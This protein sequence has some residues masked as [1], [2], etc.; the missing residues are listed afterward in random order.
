MPATS[1]APEPGSGAR[2]TPP[3]LVPGLRWRR[4]LAGD[5]RQLAVLR[6]WLASVLP[7]CPARDDL[8]SVASEL[9][10]NAIKHSASGRGG[11]FAVE[12]TWLGPVVRVAV[13]DSGGP[14]EPHMIDD[15]AGEH[16]R[17]LLL[18][19]G[20]SARTGW[21]GDCRGRLSWADVPWDDPTTAAATPRPDAY[22]AAI[23]DGESALAR[24]FAGIPAWFG[25]ATLAW[26]ALTDPP[27]LVS[28][29]TARELAGLLSRL[30]DTQ[31]PLTA[32]HAP[33]HR[34]TPQ[35]SHQDRRGWGSRAGQ[36]PDTHAGPGSDT[37]HEA[38]RAA[39]LG[40][41][42]RTPGPAGAVRGRRHPA[43]IPAMAGSA[44]S[45]QPCS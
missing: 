7:P 11:W 30:T 39:P 31:S 37:R 15:P 26:W 10:G 6:R 19:Q 36:A 13:A 24:R 41:T 5:E 20:L 4:V 12:V 44:V 25:R 34:E 43:L 42:D 28:A 17:G 32:H 21:C 3:E 29:P 27:G 16:G 1:G 22:E 23:R 33:A 2:G 40:S 38:G 14:T 9:G 8:T 45:S 35:V 18:V